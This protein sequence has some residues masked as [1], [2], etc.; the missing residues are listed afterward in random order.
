MSQP[1]IYAWPG[2]QEITVVDTADALVSLG[3][4]TFKLPFVRNTLN[5]TVEDG[6]DGYPLPTMGGLIP[7]PSG[8]TPNLPFYFRDLACNLIFNSGTIA[9]DFDNFVI[10]GLDMW[11]NAASETV[12]AAEDAV[13]VNRYSR[14]NSIIGNANLA[15]PSPVSVKNGG[16]FQTLPYFPDIN[17]TYWSLVVQVWL[18]E[19]LAADT[20]FTIQ[21]TAMTL[22]IAPTL[23][24]SD[25]LTY[26]SILP[27]YCIVASSPEVASLNWLQSMPCTAIWVE[28]SLPDPDTAVASDAVMR[29]SILQQGVK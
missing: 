2:A 9:A 4:D 27:P 11:G 14:I 23:T 10:D 8:Y 20:G 1:K 17:R 19:D 5:G 12:A 29:V 28:R 7:T 16:W 26:P 3:N 15:D 6:N 21:S 18:S 13:S 22:P 25:P 24:Y